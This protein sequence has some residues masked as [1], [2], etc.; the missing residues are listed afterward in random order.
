MKI[1]KSRSMV[2]LRRPGGMRGSAGGKL[3]EGLRSA[4]LNLR[5]EI[6][7]MDLRFGF[8]TPAL[9]YDKGGGFNRAAHSAGPD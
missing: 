5:I 3:E 4:D 2:G 9:V 1:V 7:V 8:G 6:C